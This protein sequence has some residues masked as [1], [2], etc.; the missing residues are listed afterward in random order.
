L[1]V[2]QQSDCVNVDGQKPAEAAGARS[3]AMWILLLLPYIGLLW[4]PF[5]NHLEPSLFGFPFFYW[6]QLAWVPISS[7][8][9]WLVY[10][11]RTPGEG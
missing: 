1:F 5:Y 2:Q 7:L 11:S 3:P 8:L 6:Y 9:T 4:V 10:R